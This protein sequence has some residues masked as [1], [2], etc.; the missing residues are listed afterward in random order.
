MGKYGSDKVGFFLIGGYD[1]LGVQTG[2]T[3]KVSAATED[4]LTLG[5]AWAVNLYTGLRMAEL[6]Q[7][8][9]YDDGVNSFHEQLS[10]GIGLSRVACYTVEGNTSGKN[11]IGLAGALQADYERQLSLGAL[12]KA[13]ASYKVTGKYEQGKIVRP[14]A[15]ASASGNT[16]GNAI[17]LGAS[18]PNGGAGYLQVTD[19]STAAVAAMT[20]T[21]RHSADNVTFTD[22]A[23]FTNVS[24]APSAERISSTA[25]LQRYV[26][27]KWEGSSGA[28]GSTNFRF[29]VGIAKA[30]A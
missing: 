14:L 29:L 1:A 3:E 18:S 12:H 20:V 8:G 24:T 21:L 11:F 13:K 19:L 22:W 5:V 9:F 7:E 6:S 2:F 4:G 17:D 10:G 15:S 28:G 30:E 26:A 27:A 25:A 23:S 16:T